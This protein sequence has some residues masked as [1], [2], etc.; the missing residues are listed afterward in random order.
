MNN[1]KTESKSM[2]IILG[3][4]GFFVV[5]LFVG[6]LF[7]KGDSTL[8]QGDDGTQNN[9]IDFEDVDGADLVLQN[10]IEAPEFNVK[11]LD[12][13]EIK[14]SDYKGK[15]VMLSF[16]DPSCSACEVEVEELNE[17]SK[18]NDDVEVLLV[19]IIDQDEGKEVVRDYINEL[20]IELPVLLDEDYSLIEDYKVSATPTTVLIDE[21]GI[22]KATSIGVSDKDNFEETYREE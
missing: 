16:F 10:D 14:L 20:G 15:E 12:G 21:E 7:N 2:F 8:V 6:G 22:V 18:K 1:K 4:I 3:L 19:S 9:D 11:T 5:A 17:F 13:K